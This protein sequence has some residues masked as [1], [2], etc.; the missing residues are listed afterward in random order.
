MSD[1]NNGSNITKDGDLTVNKSVAKEKRFV[2]S[3]IENIEMVIFSLAVVILIFTFF[4]RLCMVSGDSMN[5]TLVDSEKLIVTNLFYEPERGD[6]VVVHQTGALNEPIV[7]RV[8]AVGGEVVDIDFATMQ[9][10]VTDKNGN[11][12]VI[13]EPYAFYDKEGNAEVRYF[14]HPSDLSFPCT[15]P[16]GHVFL[17]GDNRYN[18]LDSRFREIGFVDERRILGKVVFRVYPFDKIGLID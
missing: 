17:L 10:T 4:F 5:N 18:S 8:I 3:M 14:S 11:S 15:V 16:E 6:I 1:L 9:I 13:D 7:K 12:R 2:V